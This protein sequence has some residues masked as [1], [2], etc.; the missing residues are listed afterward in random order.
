MESGS[1]AAPNPGPTPASRPGFATTSAPQRAPSALPA[2]WPLLAMLAAA[3]LWGGSFAAMRVALRVLNPWSLMWVRMAVGVALLAPFAALRLPRDL[4]ASYRKGDWKLLALLMASEPCLYFLLESNALRFTTSS[5]A[6]V[7]VAAAPLLVALGAW[8]F[9]GE[10]MSAAGAAGIALSIAGVAGLTLLGASSGSASAAA[11]NAPLGN[12]LEM[13]AMIVAAAY[14]LTSS[15]L[16]RRYPPWSLTALQ[17][18]AGALFFLPGLAF[19]V[20]DGWQGFP[21]AKPGLLV[22]AKAGL[23][24]SEAAAAAGAGALSP[25]ALVAVLAFLGSFVTLAAFGC[26]N[27]GLSRLPAARASLFLNLIPVIAVLLGWVLLGESLSVGQ[28]LSAAAVIGGVLLGQGLG[29]R[30]P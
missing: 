2:V 7:I 30:R 27:W 29:R 4:R 10:R 6:G 1:T 28:C 16:G 3:L 18:A 5:Q 8:L 15:R 23:L 13:G 22:G 11:A 14:T 12:T 26:Y 25:W 17:L 20:R 9:L 24:V 21:W 19:L